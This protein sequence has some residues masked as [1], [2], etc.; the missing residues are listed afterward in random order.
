M[1]YKTVVIDRIKDCEWAICVRKND[2]T[3]RVKTK[4]VPSALGFYH[5]PE[6]VKD[7]DAAAELLKC[8]INA[9]EKEIKLLSLSRDKLQLLLDSTV[10]C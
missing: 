9:H 2:L 6:N 10:G 1:I 8:M 3:Q 5:V 7:E 4:T